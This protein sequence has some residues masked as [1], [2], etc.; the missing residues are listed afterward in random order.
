VKAIDGRLVLLERDYESLT[1]Q[2]AAI[3]A[4][5]TAVAEARKA[6]AEAA[7]RLAE[8]R[9]AYFTK[10][11]AANEGVNAAVG[12]IQRQ[13]HTSRGHMD[14]ASAEAERHKRNAEDLSNIRNELIQE[15]DAVA[16]EMWDETNAVCPT[17]H[18]ELPA[19]KVAEMRE[20]FNVRRSNRLTTI[21]EKGLRLASKDKIEAEKAAASEQQLIAEAAGRE[22]EDLEQKLAALQASLKQPEPFETTEEYAALAAKA[23]ECRE[24]EGNA[25]KNAGEFAAS[26]NAK[27]TA[28]QNEIHE[29]QQRV[30]QAAQAEI[31]QKRIEELKVQEKTL[32]AEYEELEKGVYLC[33]QFTKAKVSALTDRIN[34]K[35]RS[36]RF[37]L[38]VEQINGGLKEDCEVMIPDGDGRM[39]PYAFA[40]NAAR[41]NAGLEIID[42]LS[43]HWGV[44]MPVV[45][46]NAESVTRLLRW[47]TLR[48]NF[49]DG[50]AETYFTV[51]LSDIV[52]IPKTGDNSQP[53]LLLG[54]ALMAGAG[55]AASVVIRRKR[56][57][58]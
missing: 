33:D 10:A 40:N 17:C 56:Q 1:A 46:D 4:G 50:Y 27:M 2:K 28:L 22:K 48:V 3:L 57:N 14:A 52:D 47:H 24:N 51:D 34:D 12:D 55:L 31:Q 20:D 21:N 49:T 13:I 44:T 18:R 43:N 53:T 42:A 9:A 30:G 7:T 29:L 32:S 5:D 54:I 23:T 58:G 39:V 16:S 26:V 37:R 38:F 41:I 36:V 25:A 6:A 8:A 11:A 35:F 19:E 45:V 15:Y